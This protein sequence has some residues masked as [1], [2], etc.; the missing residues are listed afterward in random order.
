M[1][2]FLIKTTL[3]L[4]LTT[5][6]MVILD[7][8]VTHHLSESKERV[9][10]GWNDIFHSRANADVL[11]VGS[12]RSWVHY[13][14]E[15]L[16]TVLGMSTYNLG[17]DGSGSNRHIM[18]YELYRLYNQ[19]PKV[20]IQN[21][22]Y[23]TLLFESQLDR[24]QFFPYFYNRTVRKKISSLKTYTLAE[25][26]LPMYRYANF[27]VHKIL[28]EKKKGLYKGYLGQELSWDGSSLENNPVKKYNSDPRTFELFDR[29]LSQSKAE[30]IQ[31]I[32][33]YAPIFHVITENLNDKEKMYHTFN[34]FAEKYDI[35]ILDYN[36]DSICYDTNYF[37]NPTHLNKKGSILFSLK[38]A[39]D[40]KNLLDSSNFLNK[41]QNGIT[42]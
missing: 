40:I 32:M 12:S 13:N 17:M 33:V 22:D 37:Y 24:Y 31:I 39:H 6:I 2:K 10:V 36:Y 35:P 4:T 14:P 1:R 15:I 27:G 16:D 34:Y 9:F 20:I 25:R 41:T 38:V 21:I 26:Y 5:I 28:K 7:I 18:K 8:I 23:G 11:C 29:Y 42:I 19:K 30:G 3:F